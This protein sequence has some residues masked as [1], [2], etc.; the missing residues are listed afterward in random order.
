VGLLLLAAFP[1]FHQGMYIWTER[2]CNT[3]YAVSE[4]ITVHF[5]T[6]FE[7]TYELWVSRPE[8]PPSLQMTGLGDG[9]VKSVVLI[10]GEPPGEVTFVLRMPCLTED[11]VFDDVYM[12][13]AIAPT[14]MCVWGECTVYLQE[15]V[16][17]SSSQREH[18]P[19]RD[20]NCPIT[21]C[22]G[23]DLWTQICVNGECV[24]YLLAEAN[25]PQCGYDPCTGVECDNTCEGY[26]LWTQMCEN[27]ECAPS[28]LIEANSTQCGYD[29]C[30]DHCNNGKQDCGEYGVDCGGG[31]P[32]IDSDSD[33]VEDGMDL[34]PDTPCDRVD[35]NGCETDV[36]EDDV[37]DCEDE[38][39]DERG[40]P[41]NR[42]CPDERVEYIVIIILIGGAA[43]GIIIIVLRVLVEEPPPPK[44]EE[45]IL[46]QLNDLLDRLQENKENLHRVVGSF[47]GLLEKLENTL[48]I[49]KNL[50]LALKAAE[51]MIE[52]LDKLFGALGATPLL[53]LKAILI[54]VR[55]LLDGLSEIMEKVQISIIPVRRLMSKLK[56][57]VSKATQ[58]LENADEIL[59]ELNQNLKVFMPLLEELKKQEG[60][61][62][63]IPEKNK[64][65][66]HE[67]KRK[68]EPI[69]DALGDFSTELSKL[70]QELESKIDAISEELQEFS[71]ISEALSDFV[72][73]L[74]GV[75]SAL[76]EIEETIEEIKKIPIIGWLLNAAEWTMEKIGDSIDWI[77]EKTG[78]QKLIG[79]LGKLGPVKKLIK[80]IEKVEKAQR[81]LVEP[82]EELAK[83]LEEIETSAD[84]AEQ[85]M[86]ELKKLFK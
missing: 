57:I 7:L 63:L 13:N 79:E 5:K 84:A 50:S 56:H 43:I 6:E 66:I 62:E 55:T 54:S 49:P 21:V 83:R 86:K 39:P 61:E 35:A 76:Q 75:R 12:Y 23:Y 45:E 31:C 2:G 71:E 42:G 58:S 36:D 69:I 80:I 18:D 34:C 20:V 65:A 59:D 73:D 11:A 51:K 82:L 67:I 32:F 15:Y 4:P 22:R 47:K 14:E 60:A 78:I 44:P 1:S 52:S 10:V 16:D 41:S 25:S 24:D 19:C 85:L 30:T 48:N 29:P 26:D 3:T 46:H 9:S 74:D 27:G 81:E 37:P 68:L 53:P 17:E 77:L 64:K 8:Y 72:N 33:G 38:C 40:D 70:M 28:S